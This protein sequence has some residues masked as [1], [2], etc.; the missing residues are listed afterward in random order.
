MFDEIHIGKTRMA[1][2][3]PATLRQRSV[4]LSRTSPQPDTTMNMDW[5]RF[6][7]HGSEPRSY[8]VCTHSYYYQ[9]HH[10]LIQYASMS[11]FEKHIKRASEREQFPGGK[12]V[13]I[14]RHLFNA[15]VFHTHE[16]PGP[17]QLWKFICV[18][19]D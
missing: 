11:V 4:P 14:G 16:L 15:K 6:P 19:E 3:P 2:R 18:A 8:P 17:W 9:F 13:S 5:V 7:A 1:L 12:C 10:T